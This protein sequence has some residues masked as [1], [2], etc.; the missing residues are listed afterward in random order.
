MNRNSIL[1]DFYNQIL[2]LLKDSGGYLVGG[3][4]RDLLLNRPVNDLDFALPSDSIRYARKVADELKGDFFVLDQERG[5]ARVLLSNENDQRF[6]VDFT[7]FQGSTI[8]EDLRARDFTITSMGIDILQDEKILDLFQGAQDL[9]D[10]VIRSTS[11]SSLKDDPLRCLR[12][13]RLAAQFKLRIIPE[14]REQIREYQQGLSQV[15]NERIRDE[16]FRILAGPNQTAALQVLGQLGVYNYVL[17]GNFTDLQQTIIRWLER[18]WSLLLTHH[19]QESAASWSLG[20]FVHRLGRY[21]DEMKN[22]LAYE[23]VAGRSVYQLSFLAPLANFPLSAGSWEIP[24][25]NQ[26]GSR[27][28]L[29]ALAAEEYKDIST[30]GG[31][32]VPLE[33]YKFFRSYGPG[34]IVGIFIG[35]AELHGKELSSREKSWVDALDAARILLDGWWEQR[36]GWVDPPTLLSGHDLMKKLKLDPGPK[37]GELLEELREAQVRDGLDSRKEALAYLRNLISSKGKQ[38]E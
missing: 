1:P 18:F 30:R 2:E 24:L 14:T 35:L 8:E 7:R 29:T 3:A 21:R 23:I 12:A 6:V 4:V 37:I 10:G 13:V 34:G 15:S 22:H 38:D 36:A 25:S 33:V 32:L 26:E 11:S 27:L 20:L 16:L 31:D 17:P 5:T 28:E 19:D 9:K